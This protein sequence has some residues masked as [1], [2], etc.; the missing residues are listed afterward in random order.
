[1]MMVMMSQSPAFM[2]MSLLYLVQ[3]A[4]ECVTVCRFGCPF[5]ADNADAT[6]QQN[7]CVGALDSCTCMAICCKSSQYA[8]LPCGGSQSLFIVP[9]LS[10][11]L[12]GL[13]KLSEQYHILFS[14]VMH[15]SLVCLELVSL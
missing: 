5:S 9:T 4:T 1:M 2:S 11:I 3:L 7:E 10:C 13:N 12:L 8:E 6:W 15:S 14:S